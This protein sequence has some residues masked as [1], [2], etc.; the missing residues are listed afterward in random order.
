MKILTM[1]MK[2]KYKI[3][4]KYINDLSI[5]IPD[6]E[7]LLITRNNISK[8][9]MDINISS[10]PLKNRTIEV[11]TKLTYKD[12]T[13]SKKKSY[14][15]ILY[16][17]V[18]K[19]LEEKI[20]K[21]DLEKFILCDLQLAIYPKLEKIFLNI[22]KDSGFPNIKFHKKIDFENLYNRR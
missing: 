22:L 18:I 20:E 9:T 14:F 7:T 19:I 6:P 5:E 13:K 10:K 17:T 8:Y 12:P 4:L 11:T 3:I 1:I 16:S 15:E 21:K 2:D